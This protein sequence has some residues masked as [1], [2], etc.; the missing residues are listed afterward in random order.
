MMSEENVPIETL[1]LDVAN[2]T[3]IVACDDPSHGQL[4]VRK[5]GNNND[6]L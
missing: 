5:S 4:V 6:T 1:L 3:S 2:T